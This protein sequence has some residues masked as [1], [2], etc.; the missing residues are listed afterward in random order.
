[1]LFAGARSCLCELCVVFMAFVVVVWLCSFCGV[2][3][4]LPLFVFVVGVGVMFYRC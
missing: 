1:M 2:L 4:L 3:L